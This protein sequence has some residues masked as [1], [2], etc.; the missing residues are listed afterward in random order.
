M[1]A[2]LKAYQDLIRTILSGP[3]TELGIA[4]FFS[5]PIVTMLRQEEG[6]APGRY[7]TAKVNTWLVGNAS[8]S[9]CIVMHG[10]TTVFLNASACH[11]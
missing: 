11:S 2:P 7:P 4:Y 10:T 5:P 8:F 3:A 6:V 9:I 1:Q